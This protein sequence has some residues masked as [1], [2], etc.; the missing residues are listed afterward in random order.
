MRLSAFSSAPAEL[1]RRVRNGQ[2]GALDGMNPA[3]LNLRALAASEAGSL[4]Y[5]GRLAA[6]SGAIDAAAGFLRGA[7]RY[8]REPWRRQAVGE[9]LRIEAGRSFF[10][11]A[12]LLAE[13]ALKVYPDDV[14]FKMRRLEAL[15][16]AGRRAD[17]MREA[18]G[19]P[20][21]L[22]GPL[23]YQ[24]LVRAR[25]ELGHSGR[26]SGLRQF[27]STWKSQESHARILKELHPGPGSDPSFENWEIVFFR[28]KGLLAAG[29]HRAAL[30]EY[31]LVRDKLLS[32]RPGA[33]VMA[34]L[35]DMFLKN[36][37][38]REG[39]R[40]LSAAAALAPDGSP[41]RSAA[42]LAAGKLFRESG[43]GAKS[44]Q[45][46]RAA[47]AELPAGE[48]RDR[49][50][51]HLLATHLR[52]SAAEAAA[53]L[54]PILAATADKVGLSDLLEAVSSILVRNRDWPAIGRAFRAVK[55]LAAGE[56]QARFAFILGSVLKLG[57][58]RGAGGEY[59]PAEQYLRF[60]IHADDRGYYRLLAA[61]LL[62]E[63]PPLTAGST[64]GATRQHSADELLAR[65]ALAYGL[66]EDAAQAAR[67]TELSVDTLRG[68]AQA[69]AE[70]GLQLE[71]LRVMD[72]LFSRPNFS[73][74]SRD[75]RLAYPL[76]FFREIATVGSEKRL[77]LLLLYALVREESY[78][79]AGIKSSAGAV[80][81]AQLMP[82]TARDLAARLRL[83][84]TDLTDPAF[85]LLL[86]GQYLRWL[87][88]RFSDNGFFALAAYNAGQG[89]VAGWQRMLDG[90][91]A[92][93]GA[94]AVP[95]TETRE[96]IRKITLTAARYGQL[97][98][99]LPP[100]EAVRL[101]FPDLSRLKS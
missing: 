77:S 11:S 49:V 66:V 80:G 29:D 21:G 51:W 31:R 18:G 75:L 16:A 68:L 98:W 96:Y 99:Y 25:W 78:F 55:G 37:L 72:R 45:V 60:A 92:V 6:R 101:I 82:A 12:A 14:E 100:L 79:D 20:P 36:G 50:L 54:E 56:D 69:L 8:E 97:Y 34:E 85:N 90:L 59:E 7:W 93:L 32:H 84:L 67:K 43:D 42:L 86:G 76:A 10:E 46:L 81:L 15:S 95:F 27:F 88:D 53:H 5:L 40:E 26:Q 58:L 17:F 24:Q 63:A 87:M 71:S 52:D 3:A 35:G 33:P 83:P 47:A 64:A 22:L 44:I 73:P 9:L 19:Q 1:L 13:E 62:G 61:V 48:D 74:D 70:R 65:G 38:W 94:E 23:L 89:R 39:G 41:A 4:Y 91:P 2:P 28:M 30:A 57:W